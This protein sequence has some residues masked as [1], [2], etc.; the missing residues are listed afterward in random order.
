LGA[1]S[2]DPLFGIVDN[3][4]RCMAIGLRV[5]GAETGQQE[6]RQPPQR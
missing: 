1:A 5:D 3:L 6:S 2:G 4:D